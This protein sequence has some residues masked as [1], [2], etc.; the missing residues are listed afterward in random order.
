MVFYILTQCSF[1]TSEER[2]PPARN[3][4]HGTLPVPCN[5]ISS[6][7]FLNWFSAAQPSMLSQGLIISEN[8]IALCV[9]KSL[10]SISRFR[11]IV[12]MR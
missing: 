3:A 8:W 5:G 12:L 1:P 7:V 11:Q 2:F 10:S 9:L 4:M 6:G